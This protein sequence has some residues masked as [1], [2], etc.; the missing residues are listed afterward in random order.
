MRSLGY[1][2]VVCLG[3]AT[4]AQASNPALQEL[5]FSACAGAT[6]AL[7]A[8][9]GETPDGLG[10]LS[11]DSE[12]SLNPSQILSGNVSGIE[13]AQAKAQAA[14]ERASNGESADLNLGPFSLLLNA[15]YSDEERRRDPGMDRER[16]YELSQ[17]ALELGFDYRVSDRVVWGGIFSYEKGKLDFAG[18]RPGVNFTPASRAGRTDRDGLG[19]AVFAAY[20]FESGAY[21]DFTAGYD[22]DDLTIERRSVFQETTRNVSQTDSLTRG[23]TDGRQW[24]TSLNG[25][26]NWSAGANGYGIYGGATYTRSRIDGYDETDLSNSGLAMS[27]ASVA[28]SSLTGRVGL[29]GQRAV[30]TAQGVLIPQARVE[31]EREFDGEADSTGAAYL[32]DTNRNQLTLRGDSAKGGRVN[33]GLGLLAVLPNG[34]MPFIDA[35]MLVGESNRDRY[36]IALGLRKEL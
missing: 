36:R 1:L 4:T 9:C 29:R 21:L 32:L 20:A 34:W 7:A 13:A 11:G 26:M 12:S 25:G 19:L 18:E 5:F 31:Y 8:R 3:A 33:L 23:S 17:R 22:W 15:R 35:E 16:G 27:F 30:S 28:R 14:R 24:W 2:A 6:G 10:N